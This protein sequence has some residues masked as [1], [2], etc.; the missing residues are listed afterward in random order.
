MLVGFA[1]AAI[2]TWTSIRFIQNPAAAEQDIVKILKTWQG[3]NNL[4]EK[5]AENTAAEAAPKVRII[6]PIFAAVGALVF[7]GG[8][9][10]V[11]GKHYR[12]AQIACVLAALNLPNGCCMPGAI[13]GFWAM[14]LLNSEA[15]REHFH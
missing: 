11:R 8:I 14:L 1:S 15:G 12:F 4:G 5:S 13:F 3:E 7:F 6:V 2:N 9:S 10:I